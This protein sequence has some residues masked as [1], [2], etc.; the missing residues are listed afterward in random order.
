ML[1]KIPFYFNQFTSIPQNTVKNQTLAHVHLSKNQDKKTNTKHHLYGSSSSTYSGV[2]NQQ[3]QLSLENEQLKI[4]H[5][6]Y[7]LLKTIN[8]KSDEEKCLRRNIVVEFLLN[9]L[10]QFCPCSSM[11]D[12]YDFII[13]FFLCQSLRF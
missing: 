10:F 9:A 6:K 13:V 12:F 11:R 2:S 4:I 8:N 5:G 1:F 3:I 7:N